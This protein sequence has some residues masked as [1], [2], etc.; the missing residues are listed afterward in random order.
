MMEHTLI[1]IGRQF[2]SGGHEVG[3]RLAERLDIPLYDHNLLRMA[4]RELGVSDEDVAKVDET[5]LGR[6]LSGYVAGSGE[7]TAFMS[8]EEA[9]RPL[10]DR[11][12]EAQ[13]ELIRRLA[14][15]G[16]GIFVGR[17]ADYIFRD[18]RNVLNY[19]PVDARY[20]NCVEVLKMKPEEAT[21]MI[22]KVDKARTAYH[23]RYAKY[24]PGDLDSK[25]IMIDSS[26]L[27]VKGT[28]EVLA[29]IVQRRFG[30]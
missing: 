12:F 30:L 28:A 9:G 10:S 1:T 25:Q 16:P 5:M 6:F 24:A 23:K 22:Y 26:M 17:C 11:L 15:R 7:Y 13:S 14:Q 4:A 18:H 2:G 21:K 19:A 29:E 8:G 20:K 3:N 27:G